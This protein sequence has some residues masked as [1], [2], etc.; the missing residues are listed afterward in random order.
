M[1]DFFKNIGRREYPTWKDVPPASDLE[2]ISADISKVV[3]F[4]EL[5][6]APPPEPK[7]DTAGKTCYSLGLTD[8][9]RVS[10]MVGYSS[11]T[12]SAVGVQNLIDHLEL[13]KSQISQ[14]EIE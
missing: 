12:M 11:V 6:L 9:N 10:L 8:N 7:E 14:E 2:K 1:F 5:K 4:P 13:L 3:P